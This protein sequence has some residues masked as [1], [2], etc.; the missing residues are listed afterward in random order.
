MKNLLTL[1]KLLLILTMTAFSLTVYAD[2]DEAGIFKLWIESKN[3]GVSTVKFQQYNDLC[4]SCHFAYQPGLL[5]ALSWENIMN[6]LDNHFGQTIT[7]TNVETRTMRRY[8]LDNSAGH[9]NDDISHKILQ[10]LKYNPIPVRIT[11]TPYFMYK[12]EPLNNKE[13]STTANTQTIGQCDNCHQ[14]ANQGD[15]NKHKIQLPKQSQWHSNP[16]ELKM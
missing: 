3:A 7:M 2:G 1:S 14:D 9:V 6:Q 4:G 5:P 16:A 12:H 10:S 15:Y 8:L 11:K 13:N